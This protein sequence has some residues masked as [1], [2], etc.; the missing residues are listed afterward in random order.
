MILVQNTLHFDTLFREIHIQV[1][2]IHH[3]KLLK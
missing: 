3:K 1:H 2:Y